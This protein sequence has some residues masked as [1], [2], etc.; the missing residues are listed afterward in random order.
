M[1][2]RG[3]FM[4]CGNCGCAN[5]YNAKVCVQCKATLALTDHYRAK[6]FV[7]QEQRAV[8]PRVE[9]NDRDMG[10][11][12]M[13]RNSYRIDGRTRSSA[14]ANR[15]RSSSSGNTS[16]SAQRKASATGKES[17]SRRTETAPT[18]RKPSATGNRGTK[19]SNTPRGGATGGKGTA[20]S[21]SGEK[22][23]VPS[24]T[25][26]SR[27]SNGEK[28]SAQPQGKTKKIPA[29]KAYNHTTKSLSLAEKAVK[30]KNKKEQKKKK[31]KIW[32][33]VLT[34][35]ILAVGVGI[36][37]GTMQF[38]KE[39]DSFI[40]T[41][42]AFAEALVMDDEDAL[43]D[44][45]HPKMYNSLYPLNYENVER[46]ETKIVDYSQEETEALAAELQI[47]YGM[48][49]P[50]GT[51]YRVRVG[52]TVYGEETYA[53]AMDVLVGRIGTALYVLKAENISD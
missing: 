40:Q 49:D 34:F 42:A 33:W 17:A 38:A 30:Q 52:C 39:E 44:Y 5:E 26:K 14:T 11:A 20:P 16:P 27:A 8:K 43:G 18:G 21:R 45:I 41:A 6:G 7:E 19:T 32:P 35:V 31:K 51:L 23:S 4:N 10:T 25:S 37:M 48:T 9:I 28:T 13:G 29:S 3:V 53:C 1:G 24:E 15:S 36:F 46:C 47:Q 22:K 2:E 12:D 50:I